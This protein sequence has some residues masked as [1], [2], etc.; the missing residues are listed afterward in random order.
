MQE[1]FASMRLKSPALIRTKSFCCYHSDFSFGMQRFRLDIRKNFFMGASVAG[2]QRG[3]RTFNI[4]KIQLNKVKMTQSDVDRS[5]IWRGGHTLWPPMVGSSQH[6]CSSMKCQSNQNTPAYLKLI[7][8][9][10]LLHK[11]LQH[12]RRGAFQGKTWT[13]FQQEAL[14]CSWIPPLSF[15]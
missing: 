5:C 7:I 13:V 12:Q 1:S 15:S 10:S 14:T 2:T 4:I 3:C 9:P 6:V 11:W 8:S